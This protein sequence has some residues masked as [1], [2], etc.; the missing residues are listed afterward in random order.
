MF[1]AKKISF[2]SFILF[3]LV[4]LA[5]SQTTSVTATVQYPDGQVF[6]NGTVTA[7]FTP[8]PGGIAQGGYL[9]NGSA[10]LYTVT[11]IMNGSG[12]FTITLTDDTVV[13]PLGGKWNFVLCS[14]ASVQCS[15]S[16][17]DVSGASL[18]LSTRINA[19]IKPLLASPL[20]IPRYYVDTEVATNSVGGQIYYNIPGTGLRCWSGVI[21]TDCS[22]S[23]GGSVITGVVGEPAIYKTTSSVGSSNQTI[24][25][26]AFAGTHWT[27]KVVAAYGS[28]A[29]S[30]GCNIL[31]PDSIA[32]DGAA[33]T[34]SIPTNVTLQF[35]GNATFGF[36]EL[37]TG[38]FSKI[39]LGNITL[40]ETLN[41]CLGLAHLGTT[42]TLQDANHFIVTGGTIDCN[43]KTTSTGITNTPSANGAQDE[44]DS[45]SVKNCTTVGMLFTGQFAHL[46]NLLLTQNFVNL[47]LYSVGGLSS[48]T[49]YTLKANAPSS[50][51]NVIVYNTAT[52][53]VSTGNLFINPQ[54][55]NGTIVDMA[56]IGNATLGSFGT[57]VDIIGGSPELSGTSGSTS[58]TIDGNVIPRAGSLY[59]KQAFAYLEETDFEDANSNPEILLVN[60]SVLSL[61]DPKGY[62]RTGGTLVSAD[63]TSHVILLGA[64]TGQGNIGGVTS[65]PPH[66]EGR[67]SWLSGEPILQ[68]SSNIIN[69]SSTN[70]QTP[71]ILSAVG[72][73]STGTAI[74][75]TYNLVTTVT[76]AASI[77]NKN[78]N[79]AL[80][81]G[82]P[83]TSVASDALIT[84]LVKSSVD[85]LISCGGNFSDNF[86]FSLT[87]LI[88]GQ[89]TR[90][91]VFN[92]GIAPATGVTLTCYSSDAN[93]ATVS[94]TGYQLSL[95]P[96]G[97]QASSVMQQ[98]LQSGTV[99]INNASPF[100][101]T[102]RTTADYTTD[103][104][105]NFQTIGGSTTN[106]LSWNLPSL[107]YPVTFSFTCDLAY[108]QLVG[109]DVVS[110]GI[111]A[112]TNNPTNIFATGIQYNSGVSPSLSNTATLA[113]LTTTTPTAIVVSTPASTGTQLSVHLAGT[114]ENP[115]L[116]ANIFNIMVKTNTGADLVTTRRGAFCIPTTN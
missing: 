43:S 114:I 36:C 3:V 92:G 21:W 93:A 16:L 106:N 65:Y 69:S 84:I 60:S 22:G 73:T 54:L 55:Q 5:Q 52:S 33:T 116:T 90:V 1:L 71:V 113:T 70:P 100:L 6:A 35:T 58:V 82:G 13:R 10:F 77:G 97:N 30:S 29:C 81:A 68:Y 76:Y 2:L 34:P 67:Y 38:R 96:Q 12:T 26:S 101:T 112:A 44:Y 32:D 41:N 40:Q 78:T 56:V 14:Q 79:R 87:P 108:L 111:Q 85:K 53:Q 27:D 94:F 15:T 72:T 74:D 51:V 88:A 17:Q 7:I 20:D 28:A 19:D 47:K 62:G 25:A 57:S 102:V 110:F 98:V 80:F 63:A 107:P 115:A 109:N 104:T 95:F 4:S 9:L 48:N 23:G 31:V 18:N 24:D 89:W 91:V 49:F 50:G 103:G 45:V 99:G 64:L 11:G 75:P 66:I 86:S 8:V 42:A 39:Y 59:L 105:T 61:K 46:N 83:T 37:D